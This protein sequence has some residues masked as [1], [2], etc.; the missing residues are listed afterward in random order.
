MTLEN[1]TLYF[2]STCPFCLK[3]LVGL[4]AMGL[5]VAQKNIHSDKT[6]KQELKKGG[7]KTQVPCLRIDSDSETT[8]MYESSDILAYLKRQKA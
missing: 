7:G 1:H 8:W 2:Y 3:V 5:K 4:K 6:Y